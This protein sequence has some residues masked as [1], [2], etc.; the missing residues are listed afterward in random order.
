MRS[1]ITPIL[2]VAAICLAILGQ[3]WAVAAALVLA[4]V[5]ELAAAPGT[6]R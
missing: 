5:V 6:R 4:F 2:L 3:P 1:P